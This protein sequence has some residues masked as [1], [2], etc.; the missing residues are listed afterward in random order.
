MSGYYWCDKCD[1][2][3]ARICQTCHQDARWIS[4]A[5]PVTPATTGRRKHVIVRPRPNPE[6]ARLLFEQMRQICAK[7]ASESIFPEP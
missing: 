6:N 7:T 2:A 5:A 4:T 3:A 1:E